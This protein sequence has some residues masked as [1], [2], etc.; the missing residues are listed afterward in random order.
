MVTTTLY[1]KYVGW[2]K[3]AMQIKIDT[4]FYTLVKFKNI[5]DLKLDNN[6]FVLDIKDFA[7]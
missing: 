1:K 2:N 7:L 6:V 4:F 3:L 5:S